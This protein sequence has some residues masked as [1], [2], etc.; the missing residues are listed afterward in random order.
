MKNT[1][2]N[3]ISKIFITVTGI[4]FLTGAPGV[5]SFDTGMP[6]DV[7]SKELRTVIIESW[8]QEAEIWKVLGDPIA[9]QSVVET[10][11][12]DG[13]PK[14]LGLDT[15]N[16]KC[17]G[18][19]FQFIYP[20]NNTLV[21]TPPEGKS[22]KR[23]MQLLDDKTG[24]PKFYMV[25]GIELPGIVKAMSIWVLGRGEEYT[26]EAWIED[27][28]GDTHIFKFGNLNFVGWRPLTITIP[29]N[30]IQE[31]DTYPQT[32]GLV[33]KKL[34]VRSTPKTKANKTVL[35]FDSIKVLTDMNEVFF[36]GA[37]IN[38]DEKDKAD[39][40]KMKQYS[41]QLRQRSQS[42][43]QSGTPGK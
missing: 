35:A 6:V 22:V 16:K 5:M 12:L 8:E 25:P 18:V 15:G 11:L 13:V 26:L 21:M 29:G 20:G 2:K 27:G 19:R 3:K 4:L 23:Y 40:E 36:D 43:S 33:L 17:L 32:K 7:D 31:N 39:K 38:F 34:V 14:N 10:K 41:D 1:M 30:V 37:D 28:R 42:G 24:E 9:P